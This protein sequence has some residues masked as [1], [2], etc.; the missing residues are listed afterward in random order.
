M[1]NKIITVFYIGP[2]CGFKAIR[3]SIPDHINVITSKPEIKSVS[4]KIKY[5]HAFIDASMKIP[6]NQ[7]IDFHGH[8]L[9]EAKL[10]FINTINNCFSNNKRCIL[11][12]T[13]K[14]AN[15]TQ[16]DNHDTSRLYYGKIRN[17]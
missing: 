2:E 5:A 4:K 16:S 6:I 3:G 15:K 14:G 17:S 11:F 1:P 10:L 12:I 9:D 13:G 7:K 8:S